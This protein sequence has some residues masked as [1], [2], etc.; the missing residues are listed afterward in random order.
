MLERIRIF[1][2]SP[3]DVKQERNA[4]GR[5]VDE[6]RR[7]VGDSQFVDLEL[8]RWETHTWPAKGRYSQDVVNRQ[9]GAYDI[10]IGVM[11][12]RFGTPTKVAESGTVEEFQR[13]LKLRRFGRQKIMFYLKTQQ[14]YP[15]SET[16]FDD[17]RKVLQFKKRLGGDGIL[18]AEVKTTLD[19]ERKVR[20]HLIRE[21]LAVTTSVR[22]KLGIRR[23]K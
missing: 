6:I 7:T 14:F 22:R 8:V 5:V 15:T 9:I 2:A 13:A 17:F 11:W 12:R 16:E 23:R 4:L 21:V 3:S 1:I 19:F 18:Y 10:F 20:E